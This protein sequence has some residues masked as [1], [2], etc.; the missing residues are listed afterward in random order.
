MKTLKIT[1]AALAMAAAASSFAQEAEESEGPTGWTPLAVGV[2]TPVQ[3][4]WGIDRWDIKGLDVNLFYADAP[5][6][7]G[8][9]VSLGGTQVR[10]EFA[11]AA[12]GG[13]FNCSRGDV[14]GLRVTA[15][16]NVNPGG[17]YGVDVDAFGMRDNV[18]GVDVNI[19]ASA[20]RNQCGLQVSGL[21]NVTAVESYG[22]TIAGLA[23]LARTA[24]GLQFAI[25]YNMTDDL[26][27]AQIGL[28][29]YADN[30][31]NG[32]FQVGLVN[33]ILSNK[34]KVLPFLNGYF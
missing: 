28:V 11:G 26:H 12:V 15:G 10:R 23:N 34:I 1:L 5:N 17:V 6:L 24:Y 33:I 30:C 13:L 25:V 2:A 14:Y 9:I 21:A 31:L 19:L 7:Q 27:G 18:H 3:L 29:N 32:G 22:C 20:Q 4:P 8:L 16:A